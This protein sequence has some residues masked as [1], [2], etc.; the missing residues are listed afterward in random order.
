MD[1]ENFNYNLEE[2]YIAKYPIKNK[3]KTKLLILDV[4][5]NEIKHEKF[6][7]IKKYITKNDLLILNNT[8]VI[9]A[10]INIKYEKK[11]I[12]ILIEKKINKNEAICL[13]KKTLNVKNK[14]LK[15]NIEKLKN[16]KY[17]I[18]TKNITIKNLI[19]NHGEIPLPPYIKRNNESLDNKYYQTVYN[20]KKGSIAAPTAGLHFN[21]NLIKELKKNGIKIGY[22]TLHINSGT[23]KPINSKNINKH[24]MHLEYINISKSLCNKIKITKKKGG[25]IF[26][27]GTTTVRALE[28]ANKNGKIFPFKGETNIFIKPNFNFKIT[29]AI[30][31]N[32]HLPKSTLI[33]L[34]SAFCNINTIKKVYEEAKKKNY[35]F[36]T[37]GDAM[38]IY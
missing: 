12:V 26:A 2:K 31:T 22:I 32:F 29:D 3:K 17:K 14:D 30:I 16:R 36:Y 1:L 27:C 11:N 15:L 35:R 20:S 9:S 5:K 37:Y 6:I 19:K 23:F 21:K 7:N 25:K 8:S 24:K 4:K 18:T 28:T 10:K 34:V 38:L 33:V 13:S